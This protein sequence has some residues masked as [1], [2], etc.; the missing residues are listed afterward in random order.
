MRLIFMGTPDFAAISLE[1][2]LES[3]HEILAVFS[4]PDKP[5][6]R[7]M[8][9]T[10]SPV[11]KLALTHNIPIY[12]PES[13]RDGK[14]FEIIESLSP[15]LLVVVAYGK[16]IPDDILSIPPFG[17]VNVHGSLL[18]LYRGSAP[19]QWAVLNGD[20]LSGVT[21]MYLS[22]EM[23][24]GDIIYSEETEIGEFESSGELFDRLAV[25]GAKLLVK[26]IDDIEKGIAP[27]REQ[28]HSKATYTKKLDKSLSPIDFRKSPRE[29]IK[30]I[31]G[32]Q[33]WPVATMSING[34]VFRVFG[35]TYSESKTNLAC[36]TVIST[37]SEG[38]EISCGSGEAV[39]ITEIQTAGGKRMKVTDYLRGNRID[40]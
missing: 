2:L 16:I 24:S 17:A 9:K 25:M 8:P 3:G 21:T 10:F 15:E 5:R 1:S 11:K 39:L 22:S 31:Y 37:G 27:R 4:Q 35:A 28:D 18:P 34:K 33:P 30:H 40:I 13:L 38:I 20:K 19:I 6:G 32:L 7:G 12:Q 29:I 36:G 26:T 23:D 14:T